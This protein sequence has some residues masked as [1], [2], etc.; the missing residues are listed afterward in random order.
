MT[1]A[2]KKTAVIVALATAVALIV[3]PRVG[4]IVGR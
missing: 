4:V 1:E 3:G 2:M